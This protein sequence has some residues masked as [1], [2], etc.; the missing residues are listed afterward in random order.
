MHVIAAKAVAFQEALQPA[1]KEYQ[2]Q[3]LTNAQ[4]MAAQLTK[5][6]LR[7]VSGRTESHLFLVDLRAKKVTGKDAEGNPRAKR[8][9]RSTRT[10]SPTIPRSPSSPAACASG[11][12]R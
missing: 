1:F 4:T 10:R 8:T 2:Q 5:R 3:V 6:G 11:R 12:R 9:S 7:I